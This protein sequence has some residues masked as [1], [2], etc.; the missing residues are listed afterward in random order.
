MLIITHIYLFFLKLFLLSVIM[1]I[2]PTPTLLLEF[3]CGVMDFIKLILHPIIS[4]LPQL[5]QISKKC[6]KQWC[7]AGNFGP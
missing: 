2:N 3:M 5:H 7:K 6:Q 4:L 1:N